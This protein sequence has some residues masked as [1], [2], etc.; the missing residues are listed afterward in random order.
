MEY[1]LA[2]RKNGILPFATLWMEPEGNMLSETSQS[3]KDRYHTL[4]IFHNSIRFAFSVRVDCFSKHPK[5]ERQD[6]KTCGGER[7]SHDRNQIVILYCFDYLSINVL[8]ILYWSVFLGF[9]TEVSSIPGIYRW[10]KVERWRKKQ[11][12]MDLVAT[13]RMV[14]DCSKHTVL[15]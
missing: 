12:L 2:T 15:Q 13:W 11:Q 6:R 7:D 9:Q 10:E 4:C 3:E 8:W 5:L 14:P 1:Y